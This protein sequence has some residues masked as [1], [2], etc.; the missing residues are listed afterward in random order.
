MAV[1]ERLTT[2]EANNKSNWEAWLYHLVL[3]G[4]EDRLRDS[5]RRLLAGVDGLSA[6]GA[7]QATS[8]GQYDRFAGSLGACEFD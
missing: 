8:A 6:R 3:A 7:S 2:L 1:L 4:R 5:L